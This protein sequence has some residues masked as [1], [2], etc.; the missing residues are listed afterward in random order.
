MQFQVDC[1]QELED[2]YEG[3]LKLVKLSFCASN[4]RPLLTLNSVS[5]LGSATR[6]TVLQSSTR[7]Y[8]P[9]LDESD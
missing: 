4:T 8:D 3:T 7:K 9:R 1:N 5:S 6:E 2:I